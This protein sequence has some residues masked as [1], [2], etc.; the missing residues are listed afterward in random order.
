[1][2]VK[3]DLQNDTLVVCETCAAERP[4]HEFMHEKPIDIADQ[5]GVREVGL[6]CP[7]CSSWT[8]IRFDTL[9]MRRAKSSLDQKTYLMRKSRT[10][11]SQKAYYRAKERYQAA[12]DKAQDSLRPVFG[13]VSP[14]ELL[15][16][17]G[18]EEE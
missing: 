7:E 5:P 8:H 4:L 12:H 15:E 3:N 14:S 1:M 10:E 17:H 18:D 16:Q 13:A 6:L 9:D 2:E 11:R